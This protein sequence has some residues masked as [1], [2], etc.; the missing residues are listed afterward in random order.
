MKTTSTLMTFFVALLLPFIGIAQE[1][2]WLWPIEGHSANDR[3]LYVPQQHIESELNFDGLV[4]EGEEGTQI[5]APENATVSSFSLE[6]LQ[7]LSYSTSFSID[8]SISIEDNIKKAKTVLG[9]KNFDT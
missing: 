1:K 5:V 3:I 9:N 2:T 4:I 8:G 7:S 6:Y